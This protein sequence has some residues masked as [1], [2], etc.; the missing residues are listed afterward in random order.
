MTSVNGNFNHISN[1]GF[2]PAGLGQVGGALFTALEGGTRSVQIEHGDRNS[3]RGGNSSI[4]YF[5]F[6]STNSGLYMIDTV[7]TLWNI[8]PATGISTMVG[9]THLNFSDVRSIGLSA[10]SNTL[11][12]AL[13]S[14]LFTINTTTGVASFVGT[15]GS[16]DFGA[17]VDMAGTVHTT[18]IVAP[19]SVYTFNPATGI[20]SFITVS[21]AGDYA[22]GL[23]PLLTGPRAAVVPE[24][25]SF[26]LIAIGALLGTCG[27]KR[28]RS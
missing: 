3:D 16:T 8:N 2:L 9:S 12:M 25:G 17:I 15:S 4:S 1:L 13:N 11:Y 21:N 14:D 6:G 10:G 27:L 28:K 24:P 19:N 5:G 18:T 20:S 7:G 23:A 26:A 22:W